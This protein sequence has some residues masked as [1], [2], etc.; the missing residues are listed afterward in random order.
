MDQILIS[1]NTLIR[2]SGLWRS[3]EAYLKN[4]SVLR[5][6]IPVTNLLVSFVPMLNNEVLIA[7]NFFKFKTEK[8]NFLIFKRALPCRIAAAHTLLLIMR[9]LKM[10]KNR[11]IVID[12][13]TK[14]KMKENITLKKNFNGLDHTQLTPL[15]F[16]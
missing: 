7:V 9:Q 16:K 4:I 11:R 2:S 3:H 8:N 12:F 1:C 5:H 10:E 13:F 6:L 14:S 15:L